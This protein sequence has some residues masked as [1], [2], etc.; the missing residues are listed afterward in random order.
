M[1]SG[2]ALSGTAESRTLTG[3]SGGRISSRAFAQALRSPDDRLGAFITEP[4][5]YLPPLPNEPDHGGFAV[6]LCL[7][8]DE[9]E[10][11]LITTL[12]SFATAVDVTLAELRLGRPALGGSKRDASGA[13]VPLHAAV[14]EKPTSA[15]AG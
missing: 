14:K 3:R 6:P 5:S 13:G 7:R 10:L 15:L 11:R 1:P 8:C 4:E 12:T 2:A 9:G